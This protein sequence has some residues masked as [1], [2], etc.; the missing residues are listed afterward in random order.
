MKKITYFVAGLVVGL[1][2][3][4][5]KTKDVCTKHIIGW[6]KENRCEYG[7]TIIIDKGL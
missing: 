1:I 2:V 5:L 6:L 7:C 4:Q 3:A